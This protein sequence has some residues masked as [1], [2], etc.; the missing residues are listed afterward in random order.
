MCDLTDC[1]RHDWKDN[2]SNLNFLSLFPLCSLFLPPV[3]GFSFTVCESRN[4]REAGAPPPPL[5]LYGRLFFHHYIPLHLSILHLHR[6]SAGHP[7]GQ[8]GKSFTS[9]QNDYVWSLLSGET[10]HFPLRFFKKTKKKTNTINK[11]ESSCYD[12][13]SRCID[14]QQQLSVCCLVG[15]EQF[16]A[17]K[18]Q[19]DSG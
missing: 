9:D 3:I 10:I 12:N 1:P 2:M 5:F 17:V 11:K 15:F 4:R 19:T 6:K 14:A 13:R 8:V 7:H 18:L 16:E